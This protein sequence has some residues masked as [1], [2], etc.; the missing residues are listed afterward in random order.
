MGSYQLPA[1]QDAITLITA[2]PL[3]AILGVAW[4]AVIAVL[5]AILTM[6]LL[7]RR[8]ATMDVLSLRRETARTTQVPFW[9]RFRL[10]VIAAVIALVGYAISLYITS[11]GALLD[12]Q[13]RILVATPLALVAPIFLLNRRNPALLALL[14][15]PLTMRSNDYGA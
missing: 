2:N 7:L 10:D 14:S 3:Q 5:V 9:Q 1:Q 12:I 6:C 11:I 15:L 13:A 4:Y 8:A